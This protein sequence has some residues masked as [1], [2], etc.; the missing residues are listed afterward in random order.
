VNVVNAG[1]IDGGSGRVYCRFVKLLLAFEVWCVIA[2]ITLVT[3]RAEAMECDTCHGT[4]SHSGTRPWSE[5][6]P[7]Y[8][9]GLAG[10]QARYDATAKGM[11][12]R[13]RHEAKRRTV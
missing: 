13:V 11:L 4:R 12:R 7:D 2:A 9:R 5:R 1:W 3:W 6:C 10:R 8:D